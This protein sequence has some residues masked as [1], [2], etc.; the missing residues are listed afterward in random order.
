MIIATHTHRLHTHTHTH[1]PLLSVTPPHSLSLALTPPNTTHASGSHSCPDPLRVLV[2]YHSALAIGGWVTS[3]T[4]MPALGLTNGQPLCMTVNTV[5]CVLFGVLMVFVRRSPFWGCSRSG[6]G[7]C[8]CYHFGDARGVALDH[9]PAIT[10]KPTHTHT[11]TQQST[12]I[13]PR[14]RS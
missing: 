14:H 1:T 6:T 3:G 10:V 13:P 12:N 8:T 7:L 2:A 9:T 4:P 5:L 11:C